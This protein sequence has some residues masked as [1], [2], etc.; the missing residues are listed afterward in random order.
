MIIFGHFSIISDIFD[1]CI[2]MFIFKTSILLQRKIREARFWTS[3]S[4]YHFLQ[5]LEI[6]ENHENPKSRMAPKM[7]SG[8]FAVFKKKIRLEKSM[9]RELTR[10]SGVKKVMYSS[11][12]SVF[13]HMN[14]G[15][16]H[17]RPAE[18]HFEN[19]LHVW[20]QTANSK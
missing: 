7:D 14:P 16:F 12:N 17:L 20:Y 1:L 3:N 2:L 8:I 9:P 18:I 6:P 11:R 19:I 10:A 13:F 15:K 5:N 4:D